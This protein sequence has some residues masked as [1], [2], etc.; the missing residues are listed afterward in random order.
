VAIKVLMKE[1]IKDRK[2]VE[3]ITREIKILKKVRHPHVV[4]LY[5]VRG[6]DVKSKIIETEKE[7]YL[8]TEFVSGG[9]LFDHIVK[10]KRLLE[11]HACRLYHQLLQAVEY[12]HESGIVHRDLKP[13]N[14]LLD[15]DKSLKLVDFGLGNLYDPGEVLS[16]AC[17]SPCYAAPEMIAGKKYEGLR[18][19]VWSTGVILY[20]MVC[21]YL[22]FEDPQ[23]KI[24]YKKILSADY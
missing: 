1:K 20:A 3:R 9:E 21:G 2:D 4:H 23:T 5:E 24:L 19:D 12:I 15:Y 14:L 22:P 10:H 6:V 17:G 13:E 11:R 18:S 8:V 7:L 16:T